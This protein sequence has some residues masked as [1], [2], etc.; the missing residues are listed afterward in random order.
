MKKIF[1][2]LAALALVLVGFVG[3]AFADHKDSHDPKG[4]PTSAPEKPGK[5]DNAGGGNE[6]VTICHA[7]GRVGTTKYVTLTI[8]KNAVY[9][10]NGNA[11]HFS[12]NGT[13]L[14]GHEQDY[15]GAC[16]TDETPET[17]TKDA[18]TRTVVT[19]GNGDCDTLTRVETTKLFTTTYV[20]NATT[21]KFDGTEVLTSTTNKSVAWTPVGDECEV[22]ETPKPTPTDKPT[23][24][25]EKP[26]PPREQPKPPVG[27]PDQATPDKASDTP[28]AVPTAVAAG[29][30]TLPNTG[31]P[32]WLL[33][34]LGLLVLGSG[35]G[36]I[37]L[38]RLDKGS[39][40]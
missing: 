24:P 23:V 2:L 16:S 3:P 40:S 35:L 19:L 39:H 38:A 1:V 10:A 25:T 5:P 30:E 17:P 18:T 4:K 37:F 11:G 20:W 27:T 33:I 14:A 28:V 8:S 29:A 15:F 36:M 34:G 9:G 21:K 7:A 13:P 31:G 6:K 32:D 26:E 12:E 22:E